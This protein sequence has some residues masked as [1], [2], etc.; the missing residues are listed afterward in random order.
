MS[1]ASKEFKSID[2]GDKR[3]NARVAVLADRLSQ[4]P[5]QSIPN[6]CQGWRE[7][8]A[9]Y[10]F[11]ANEK[12]T[13]QNILSSHWESTTQRMRGHAVVLNIQDTT[14]LNF[15]G[16]EIE[17]LGPLS[18]EAQRGMYLHPTYAITPERVPLGVMDA[19][20]WTREFRDADGVRP[21]IKESTRWIEGYE[22]VAQ[23]ALELPE[24]RQ[25]Y[26]AD[27]EADIHALLSR[28]QSLNYAADVLIR[29]KHNRALPQGDKLWARVE[30]AEP[31][32]FVRFDMASG[33]G[34][35]ARAVT[36]ELRA[37]RVELSDGVT[38]AC[39]VATEIDAPKGS[40]P[41]VWRLLTNRAVDT[42]EQAIELID[43]YRARWE[44]EM[45]FLI[46]KEGCR[47][48]SLQL[49]RV[50]RIE[51]ALALYM[52]IAW[53]VNRLM[54]LG[55]ALPK[56]PVDLG[57]EKDEW[58][59]AYILNKKRPPAKPPDLNTVVRLVAQL[60]GFIGRKSDG[61]PGAKTIWLG[62]EKIGAFVEGMQFARET[63]L[64]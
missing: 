39:L 47:V 53:R 12:T 17:G 2:L 56:L 36:Q 26:V 46:L 29:C 54:R 1:W 33:R 27:R 14:E 3:L 20:M 49:E 31:L 43:W 42:L 13:W 15:N 60:G 44:I 25:V 18:Y 48:E 24:V 5:T 32:G 37:A 41:V 35:K 4:N 30:Q 19:W 6:A 63:G 61:E 22:R 45:F 57:F 38:I 23:L 16:Q 52:V 50:E 55:R 51:N 40:K 62:L 21:G 28:A 11:F 59:A 8:Q 34:R 10:R 7:T 58:Q 64:A 9:A